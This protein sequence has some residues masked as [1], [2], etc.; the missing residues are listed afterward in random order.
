[1]SQDKPKILVIEDER[2]IVRF[3]R[4]A[5]HAAGFDVLTAGT[6]R[7]GLSLVVDDKPDVVVLDLG[8]PD[9]DGLTFVQTVRAWSAVPI[10]ILSARSDEVDKITVLDAGADDYLTKPFSIG[11]L[12]ARLR[13]LL[14]RRV[15]DELENPVVNFA[16]VQVHRGLRSV[17]RASAVIHLT[18]IEYQLL[19]VFLANE[20]KV[21]THRFLLHEIWGGMYSESTHYV[22]IYVG[23]LRKKLEIDAAQPK[24]FVT[25][26]GVGYRFVV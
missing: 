14:R 13:A 20:G 4:D 12:L 9:G 1:M 15:V 10:L 21:L 6:L 8:L 18:A 3:V 5:L 23:H 2:D 24:H 16:D 25:E 7:D 19:C 26:T 11:E 17:T 22:R